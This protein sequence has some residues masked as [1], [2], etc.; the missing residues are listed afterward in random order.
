MSASPF[1]TA[2]ENTLIWSVSF[3]SKDISLPKN[4]TGLFIMEGM[5]SELLPELMY[6]DL[7]WWTI[8]LSITKHFDSEGFTFILA[9]VR[10]WFA[11]FNKHWVSCKE[12]PYKKRSS[13]NAF[14]GGGELFA[15]KSNRSAQIY[16]MTIF[17][18]A[19]KRIIDA[20][21]P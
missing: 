10:Q 1:D 11:R 17:I 5:L 12:F 3:N 19:R 7:S 9:Q 8:P 14:A 2:E 13:I 15:F 16:S 20:V 6:K 18:P 4:L 21:H